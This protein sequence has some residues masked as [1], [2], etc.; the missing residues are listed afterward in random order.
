MYLVERIIEKCEN[1]QNDWR[2]GASGGRSLRIDQ[3]EY[4]ACGK[5]ALVAEAEE[6]ERTGLIRIK[7]LT[8]GSDIER[9]YYRLED[10]EQFYSIL[11]E[12]LPG[13]LPKQKQIWEYR[14]LLERELD[15]LETEWIRR[16][17]RD[18]LEQLE[19]GNIPKMLGKREVYLPCFRG[20]DGLKEPVFKRIFSSKYLHNSKTFEEFAEP[21]IIA[22][23]RAYCKDVEAE[24][25]DTEV[26]SQLCIEEYSQEMSL[27]GALQIEI[28]Q[29]EK[30]AVIDLGEYFYGT[31]LNSETLKNAVIL[32]QQPEIKRVVTIENKA[33]FVSVPYQEGTLYIFSH[34][35][36]SPREKRFLQ[37]LREVL[38]GRQ[39]EFCHSG[40]LD[41]GGVKIF[42]YIKK[43]IFPDVQPLMMDV[44]TYERYL[45]RG[46][47]IGEKTLQKLRKT[48]I[49]ELQNLIDIMVEKGIA[50]EQ[51]CFLM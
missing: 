51:E 14:G 43:H 47:P 16:Y 48:E 4:D 40:D 17:Y 35:Y 11:E 2:Q 39:V 6:L 26:L 19:K 28:V 12:T 10:L 15:V 21:H 41:Y 30:C 22:K 29:G 49:P 7:W 31:V 46:E 18:I 9:I 50:V 36:F 32:E 25:D 13:R 5:S 33:N 1:S 42:E 23:A 8:R 27:K 34:G 45:A 38:E 24:M 44:V 20:I 37:R 3:L